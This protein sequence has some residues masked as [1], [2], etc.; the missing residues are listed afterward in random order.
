MICIEYES[1]PCEFIIFSNL[2]VY[3]IKMGGPRTDP[4]GN[5]ELG[6]VS[7]EL[8]LYI[9]T[10]VRSDKYEDIHLSAL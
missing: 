4:R 6:G 9:L 5:S 1:R 7:D 3:K 2:P 8:E 10:R